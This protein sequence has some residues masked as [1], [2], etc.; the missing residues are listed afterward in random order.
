M[1]TILKILALMFV[2]TL[3]S[4]AI[5]T[6]QDRVP[7]VVTPWPVD[8]TI[9]GRI[10]PSGDWVFPAPSPAPIVPYVP[11]YIPTTPLTFPFTSIGA[12]TAVAI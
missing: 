8:P 9:P 1:S 6:A 12:P 11:S 4:T 10:G 2:L 7:P 5:A 3:A